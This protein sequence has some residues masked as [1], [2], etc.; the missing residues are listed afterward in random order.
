MSFGDTLIEEDG[1]GFVPRSRNAA[2]G[3]SCEIV[4]RY[5]MINKHQAIVRLISWGASIQSIKIPNRDGK[6]ADVVL[7]FDDLDGYLKNRY[8][9]SIIGRVAGR[10]SGG[11]DNADVTYF[12]QPIAKL[13]KLLLVL[14]VVF[15]D[16]VMSHLSRANSEGYSG[17]VLTQVNYTWTDDNQLHINIRATTTMPTP[18]N[19]TNYCL[20]NLAGHGTGSK[21]LEQ[22]VLTVNADSWTLMDLRNNLPT[23]VISPV[24]CTAFEL[25]VPAQLNRRRLYNIPGGGYD[26]NLCIN[27][28]NSW[29][30][31]FHARILHPPS[32]RFLEVYSNHPG[33]Q[34]YTGNQLPHPERVYPPDLKNCDWEGGENAK[35]NS[36][37]LVNTKWDFEI[38]NNIIPKKKAKEIQNARTKEIYGKG[39]IPYRCYGGFALSPQNYP[40]TVNIEHFPSCI[41]YPGK[42][43][44]HDMSYKFGVKLS[45]N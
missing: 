42:I 25:R 34:V 30:Y 35:I 15:F 3:K 14:F 37:K 18:I 23:G 21:E 2:F 26:H 33:L 43:Y 12:L 16:E 13:L 40:G 28:P 31:R 8:M 45:N 4:R 11:L 5:T 19:V 17:D 1:F 41:L 10:I 27:S 44:V 20:F 29:C 32:G 38:T 24:D 7:G 6:L 39:G 9:G 22:H 36:S